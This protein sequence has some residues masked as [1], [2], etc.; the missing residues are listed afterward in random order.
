M[1]HVAQCSPGIEFLVEPRGRIERRHR[2]FQ[3]FDAFRLQFPAIADDIRDASRTDAVFPGDTKTLRLSCA[4][5][6]FGRLPSGTG[7]L[8]E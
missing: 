8:I 6:T 1:R 2:F 3:E 5:V 7:T 4:T